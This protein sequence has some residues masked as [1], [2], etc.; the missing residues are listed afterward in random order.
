[1]S[2]AQAVSGKALVAGELASVAAPPSCEMV[3]QSSNDLVAMVGDCLVVIMVKELTPLCVNAVG[4]GFASL[5]RRYTKVNYFSVIEQGTLV[6]HPEA[7]R[8][9]VKVVSK[10]T[11]SIT[12]AAVV[13]NGTGFRAT[14]VRSVITAIHMASFASHPLRVFSALDPALAWLG[15]KQAPGE[16]DLAALSVELERLRARFA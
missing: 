15:G 6:M 4:R 7:R 11:Q 1:V 3:Y 2:A 5:T 9:M 10:H 16:L 13:C 14:A 8:E 12:G